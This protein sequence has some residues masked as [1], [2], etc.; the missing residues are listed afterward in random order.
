MINN[1]TLFDCTIRESGYQTGWY[2]DKKF[3]TSMYSFAQGKGIDYL[4]LGFFHDQDVD[5]NRGIYRYCSQ[6]AEEVNRVFENIKGRT[7]LSAMRDIQRPLSELI[8]KNNSVIDAIRIINRSHENEFKILEKR[9]D[10][11]RNNGYEVFVNFTS[12][13]YNTIEQN[14]E[15]AK[16]AKKIGLD[17]IYFA[18]T[19]SVF[20]PDFIVNTIE[21]CKAEGIEA[22]V[23]L[24]DKNGTAEMLLEVALNKG[25]KYTDAT[26]LG[27]GGKWHDGNLT[28]EHI[29]RRFG[30]NGGHELNRLKTDLVQQLIKYHE[31]TTAI[32][33]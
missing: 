14:I 17:I 8:P 2:F 13:G 4:E 3:V 11:I 26:L 10:E 15:F 6:K 19:E 20:T 33:E 32:L 7:K 1:I 5:P 25:C 27:L 30:I 28:I 24:H 22:G 9:V 18:D 21:I 16:F 12:A 29:L 31:H 23:H